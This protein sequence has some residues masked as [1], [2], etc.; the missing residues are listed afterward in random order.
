MN[1]NKLLLFFLFM[2]FYLMAADK[3]I[4]Y[5]Y[6]QP[7]AYIF[8]GENAGKGYINLTS[9]ILKP[10]L[11]QYRH[12][13][14]Q[15][16]VGRIM[17]DLREGKNVCVYG[18]FQTEEREKFVHYSKK[19]LLHRNVRI[20]INKTQFKT[21]RLN[22]TESLRR[23]LTELKLEL[24]LIHGRSYGPLADEIVYFNPDNVYYRASSE[25]AALFNMLDNERFDFMLA[26]PGAATYAIKTLNFKHE[27]EL[28]HIQ[29]QKP[30]AASNIGCSK[31]SWGKQTISDINIALEQAL[32]DPKY[33]NALTYWTNHLDDH[34]A[35]YRYYKEQLIN[36]NEPP[37]L[38]DE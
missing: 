22:K 13:E 30:Y 9:D 37:S 8:K 35:F 31:T 21:L 16:S 14:V 32:R 18:L 38:N 20:M 4:W 28:I 36:N 34:S 11:P 33:F 24:M 19:A 23:L 17:R 3:L 7:P 5:A 10:L 15:A 29:N 6:S 27:Y 12:I 26:F 2:P 25:S 1:I